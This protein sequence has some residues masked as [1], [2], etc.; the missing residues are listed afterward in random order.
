[1]GSNSLHAQQ[2]FIPDVQE[3]IEQF[4]KNAEHV[5]V[6]ERPAST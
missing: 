6:V 2:Q 3:I 1:M 4:E 5:Q